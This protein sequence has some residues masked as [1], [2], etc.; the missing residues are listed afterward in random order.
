MPA[1]TVEEMLRSY[2]DDLARQ[3]RTGNGN[4]AHHPGPRKVEITGRIGASRFKRLL[5]NDEGVAAGQVRVVNAVIFK[6]DESPVLDLS[7][8]VFERGLSI[9][10]SEFE[11]RVDLSF[12]VFGRSAD[13]TGTRFRAGADFRAGRVKGDF[14]LTLARFGDYACF[15]DLYVDE[16]FRAE[17][18][19]FA[20]DADFNRIRLAKSA[21][22]CS[23]FI[24]A[25]DGDC[26]VVRTCFL[27]KADFTDA[28]FGG[29]TYFKGACFGK[30]AIFDRAH[31]KSSAF[32]DCDLRRDGPD[33]KS[34]NIQ[35]R[36]LSV[37]PSAAWAGG[38]KRRLR[39]TGF[40][41]AASFISACF[42]GSVTFSGAQ[43]RAEADFRRVCIGG[44]AIFDHFNCKEAGGP[45]FV[46]VRFGGDA[47]FWMANIGG[48]AKFHAAQFGG[49][50]NFEH[51]SVGGRAYFL[52]VPRGNVFE[53]VRFAKEASFLDAYVK[54]T[55]TFLGAQFGGDAIFQRFNTDASI[56]F[57]SALDEAVQD[58]KPEAGDDRQPG[59]VEQPGAG[60]AGQP[61]AAAARRPVQSDG[62]QPP[63]E[64]GAPVKKLPESNGAKPSAPLAV[65]PMPLAVKFMGKVNFLAAN[66]KGNAEFDS[67]HFELDAVFERMF[68][69][70]SLHFRP[71]EADA[72]PVHFKGTVIF[73]GAVIKGNAEFS[74]TKFHGRAEFREMI[75]EGNAFFDYLLRY[76]KDGSVNFRD[77]IIASRGVEFDGPA[78]FSGTRFKNQ[79]DFK[80][81]QFKEEADFT[82]AVVEGPAAFDGATFSGLTKF[83][84]ASF[85]ILT[86]RGPQLS[87]GE[88]K[89]E[90]G[91]ALDRLYRWLCSRLR[92]VLWFDE[93]TRRLPELSRV[94]FSDKASLDLRGLTY[95]QIDLKLE[96]LLK[97]L[98]ASGGPIPFERQPYTQLEKAYRAVGD[99]YRAGDVYHKLRWR[100]QKENWHKLMRHSRGL[101][102]ELRR[103]DFKK[104]FGG[105]LEQVAQELLRFF[106]LLFDLIF[107]AGL[108]R[109]GV[110]P[111][112]L[113]LISVL[114]IALGTYFFSQPGAV[115]PKDKDAAQRQQASENA[116]CCTMTQA[117]GVSLNQ[118]I[119][120]VEIP[121]GSRWRPSEKLMPVPLAKEGIHFYYFSFAFYATLH[122]LFGFLLVPLGLASVTGLLHRRE[123]GGG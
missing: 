14:K 108:A 76:E 63:R 16:V 61:A 105:F 93:K 83:R 50:A 20:G 123:R 64:A 68:V 42:D 32:F 78:Y 11:C 101:L 109:Y 30:R 120:I 71:E 114:F 88:T 89:P 118:F 57:R 26:R 95:Q 28:S 5:V 39:V 92:P 2:S 84:G 82:A 62:V 96:H 10:E 58:R 75:F 69:G 97:K 27:G 74:G 77:R 51:A 102:G 111:F 23:A 19:R 55:A 4:G 67:A 44:T 43:F 13:F 112:R 116:T 70:G 47:L 72:T 45:L 60:G 40:C 48:A 66:I 117:L 1:R 65:P 21:L 85:N 24:E 25:G 34:D 81:A 31:F 91:G 59:T 99:D 46:P 29:S 80:A 86:F 56:L 103:W 121:S 7:D 17:G 87:R 54:G 3:P 53:P 36:R 6:D 115:V 49:E 8:T 35:F 107:L 106:G 90:P 119:P 52:A 15:D 113:F 100:E 41:G 104:G 38:H 73:L 18:A 98:N 12:A 122:R 79:A 33:D 110:R 94:A 9:V 37:K 22:L